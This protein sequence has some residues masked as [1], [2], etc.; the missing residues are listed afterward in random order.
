MDGHPRDV[1]REPYYNLVTG[2]IT[3]PPRLY[4]THYPKKGEWEH[5]KTVGDLKQSPLYLGGNI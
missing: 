5:L 3:A 4:I 1:G 2:E